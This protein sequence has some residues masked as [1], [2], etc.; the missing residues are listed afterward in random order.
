MDALLADLRFGLRLFRKSPVFAL[1]TI[2]TLAL[3]IGANAAIYSVVDSVLV[4]P[5]PY[6]DADRLVMVWEDASFVSFPRNTPAPGNY[7]SWKALSRAFTDIAATRGASASLTTGGPPEQV[8]GRRVTPNFFSVLGV[9]PVLGRMFTDEE[10]RSDAPV[11]IISYGLWQRRYGGSPDVIGSDT[12]M[13]GGRRTIIGVMPR[14][15]LFRNRDVDF[16]NPMH[17]T[18]SDAG[19]RGSHYLNVVARMAPGITLDRAIADMRDVAGRLAREYP[20]TNRQVGSVVVPI[21]NDLLG[22]TKLQLIVLLGAAACVLLITCANIASLLLSRGLNRRNEMAVRA[23]IGATRGRLVRQMII[24]GMILSVAGGALGI[25]LAPAGMRVLE[26][27][28]PVTVAAPPTTALDLRVVGFASLLVAAT[29]ILFSIIPAVQTARAS[30]TQS[31]QQGGRAGIGGRAFTRDALVV[32]Q[33]AVA[34]VLL[35]GAGLLIRT[36]ANLGA[37]DVGFRTERLLTLRTTLPAVKYQ[38]PTDRLAFYDRVITGVRALP[39]VENAA[40][41]STLPFLSIGNTTGYRIAGREGLPTQDTL[42]RVGT[43]D[44]LK[45]LGVQLVEGRLPDERDG[46]DAPPIVVI[47]QT[48]AR[49]QWPNESPVGHRVGFGGPDAPLR[50]IVGVVKDVR[51]RGYQLEVKPGAYA[52]YAQVLTSWLP[53]SLVVRTTGNPSDLVPAIRRVIGLV[54]PEQPVSAVRTMDD[55]VSLSVVDRRGQT[56]LLSASAGLALLLACLGLFGVLSYAVTQRTREIGVRLALG[57]T[58]GGIARLVIGRGLAPTAI[59]LTTGLA[60]A[61]VATRTIGALLVGVGTTDPA[62]FIG[63]VALLVVVAVAACGVPA[64]RAARVDPLRVLR[65]E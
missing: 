35:V 5:L 8:M 9:E 14:G 21:K 32:G 52:T 15:F 49:L 65:Q 30:L 31:L 43:A 42:Y 56:M 7:F 47:N 33:I 34:L 59:G 54:D 18:P 25:A 62:T 28:V 24:E 58:A 26:T 23:A 12:M 61:W 63:V 44:Y 57:A 10:D 2:G 38:N 55:I 6:L 16:W 51:E 3:G 13:N 1:I 39:G 27:M 11:T 22:D 29:G 4:R 36:L 53:E 19:Q 50:T 20:D 37:I 48:F 17:F 41:V 46:A 64:L 60:L 45:T 40:Y